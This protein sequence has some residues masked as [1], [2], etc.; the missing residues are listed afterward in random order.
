MTKIKDVAKLASVSISTVS[1]VVNGTRY[2]RPETKEVVEAAIAKLG[3][4]PN[5]AARALKAGAFKTIAMLVEKSTN[6]FFSEV[7]QAFEEVC[8]KQGFLL[9]ISICDSREQRQI[10]QMNFLKDRGADGYAILLESITPGLAEILR[11]D[12]E[13]P[14]LA[15]DAGE[16]AHITSFNDNSFSGGEM[17][18]AH[19][20]EISRDRVILLAGPKS[21]KRMVER[22]AGF[23]HAWQQRGL[24]VENLKILHSP[25]T[26]SAGYDT[27]CENRD[28]LDGFNG[29]MAF[30]DALAIGA[31][32]ALSEIG[33]RV[34][35]N[36]AVIGYDNIEVS[37]FA[38]PSLTT[39]SQSASRIGR[40]AAKELLSS[41]AGEENEMSGKFL[42]PHLIK[43]RSTRL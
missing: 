41:I 27:I 11:S 23:K 10:D 22:L 3:Y 15:L 31:M 34:P 35:E 32:S 12:K 40:T 39:I 7:V 25:L 24:R 4:K 20:A 16:H 19:F 9:T 14:I 8:Y 26:F 18:A 42:E 38:S 37:K 5:S 1:H 2:V 17:A 43:R 29:A 28:E 30:C 33:R 13:T 36:I 6:P 21:H